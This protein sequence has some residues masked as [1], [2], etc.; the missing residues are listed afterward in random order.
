MT[1]QKK[2]ISR[3]ELE[4][5]IGRPIWAKKA[6]KT[7]QEKGLS[8]Y[9]C[10]IVQKIEKGR[11][12]L[13]KFSAEITTSNEEIDKLVAN[14]QQ[15]TGIQLSVEFRDSDGRVATWILKEK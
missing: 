11:I 4:K 9:N 5:A 7:R 10:L 12:P 1:T 13:G 8:T 15:A 6:A 3:K 2:S 14:I